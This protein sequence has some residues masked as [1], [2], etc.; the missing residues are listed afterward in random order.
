MLYCCSAVR[1]DGKNFKCPDQPI[2]LELNVPSRIGG[3]ILT[4]SNVDPYRHPSRLTFRIGNSSKIIEDHE[5]NVGNFTLAPPIHYIPDTTW[6][7]KLKD[8]FRKFS[9]QDTLQGILGIITGWT[10]FR[11]LF[12]FTLARYILAT[13][14]IIGG[15][16]L[17]LRHKSDAKVEHRR[18]SN[19]IRMKETPTERLY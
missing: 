13:I 2:L 7:E 19:S 6:W 3:R 10:V 8:K 17:W 15:V 14:P 1:I 4:N 5:Q 11:F 16:I 9:F 12:Q 18:A